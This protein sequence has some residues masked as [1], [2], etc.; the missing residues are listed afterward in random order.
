MSDAKTIDVF[1]IDPYTYRAMIGKLEN[2]NMLYHK[3]HTVELEPAKK[4]EDGTYAGRLGTMKMEAFSGYDDKD[5]YFIKPV[6][7]SKSMD[8]SH[9]Y[10][11]IPKE[12]IDVDGDKNI[13]LEIGIFLFTKKL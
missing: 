8:I 2:P 1:L 11:A 13:D 6:W 5:F 9:M 12:K 10:Y 4:W 7:L 3:K